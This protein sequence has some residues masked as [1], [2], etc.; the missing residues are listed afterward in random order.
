MAT[1]DTPAISFTEELAELYPNALV[2]CSTREKHDWYKSASA[3]FENTGLWWLDIMFW[4]MPTLRWFGQWR[5]GMG[6]RYVSL[7]IAT[8]KQKGKS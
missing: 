4:P 7:N 5:D 2:I 1:T 3:L 6:A 8:L